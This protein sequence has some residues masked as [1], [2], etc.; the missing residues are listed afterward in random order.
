MMKRSRSS[1]SS[2]KRFSPWTRLIGLALVLGI[3][4]GALALGGCRLLPPVQG[5]NPVPPT[6]TPLANP[7]I[8]NPPVG[9]A[10]VTSLPRANI[11]Q[12]AWYTLYF[13]IPS[14]PETPADRTGGVDAAVIADF[15]R[16]Q[17]TIDA[18]V[19]DV[20]LPS[21]VDALVRAAQRGVRVRAVVDYQ[22]N[23]DAK[24]FTDAVDNLVKGGVQV[25]KEQRAALMHN[26]FAVIDQ[27]LLWTGSMNFTP[28]DVYRNNNNMLRLTNPQLIEN[29]ARRFE[30]LFTQRKLQTPAQEVPNP[31]VTLGNGVIIENYFSPNGGTQK[32][33][34]QRLK[35]AASSIR[36]TA[37]TFTDSEMASVLKSKTKAGL[38]VNA[39]FETRNN[40]GTGAQ[41]GGLKSAGVDVL[42]D[43]NCYTM[44][45][46][47]MI[48]DE[49]TVVM[50]SYNFTANANRT[51]DENVLIID[52]P[53]LAKAYVDEF[54]RIYDQAKNP[55]KCGATPLT[56]EQNN[57]Q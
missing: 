9:N 25:L 17:T 50:G 45:S 57:E 56:T 1:N 42:Q 27:Q 10:P 30:A 55:T 4:A 3:A 21:L 6:G 51:N 28:N 16:A 31:R 49:K 53:A 8:T 41:F 19:F 13:T 37:F 33:I 44:H 47:L 11:V 36:V 12:G 15:D 24:D 20:R 52:D 5:I 43:G 22:N 54:N 40:T 26:K 18:A 14:Y 34:L 29:Y 23:K 46:K 48:I 32:A 2:S 38:Q 7:P 39:V 35:D